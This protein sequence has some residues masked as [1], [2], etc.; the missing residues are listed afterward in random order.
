M[1]PCAGSMCSCG[2]KARKARR[3]FLC[4]H[5]SSCGACPVSGLHRS[6]MS[7]QAEKTRGRL[8]L[9]CGVDAAARAPFM[10]NPV[11]EVFTCRGCHT[12]FLMAGKKTGP[13]SREDLR[14]F[15][16]SRSMRQLRTTKATASTKQEGP[17]RVTRTPTECCLCGATIRR[18][19]AFFSTRRPSGPRTRT[20]VMRFAYP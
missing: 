20:I 12:P 2:Q 13:T 16:C 1:P 10:R 17:S 11:Y 18:Q 14:N 7:A 4:A 5:T 6:G 9:Q 19:K 15:S 8:A 3:F